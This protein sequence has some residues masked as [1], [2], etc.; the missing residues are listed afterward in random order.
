MKSHYFDITVKVIRSFAQWY[1]WCAHSSW[2]HTR[3]VTAILH[4]IECESFGSYGRVWHNNRHI[5][6]VCACAA[7][8]WTI[9]MTVLFEHKPYSKYLTMKPITWPHRLWAKAYTKVSVNV[10]S[11]IKRT[12]QNN[13]IA[14]ADRQLRHIHIYSE[15]TDTQSH[16]SRQTICVLHL[17]QQRAEC[18]PSAK[19]C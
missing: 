19:L 11:L 9:V 15:H 1:S 12:T 6:C 4:V 3:S 17:C 13:E 2:A 7:S 16:A 18:S 5:E 8:E 14:A 10:R